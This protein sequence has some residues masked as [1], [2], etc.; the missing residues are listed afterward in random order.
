MSDL[1]YYIISQAF[2][3]FYLLGVPT[4]KC[5]LFAANMKYNIQI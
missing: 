5:G 2:S 3:P 4:A 1:H